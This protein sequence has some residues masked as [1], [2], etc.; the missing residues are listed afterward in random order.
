[1]TRTRVERDIAA[2]P[3][4]TALLL[5]GP[6]AV[7]LWPGVTRLGGDAHH[8]LAEAALPSPR[9]G[10]LRAT[11]VAVRA[12]PPLR[13]PTSYVTRFEFRGDDVPATTGVLTLAASRTGSAGVETHASLVLEATEGR[14]VSGLRVMAGEFLANLAAAAEQRSFAA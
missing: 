1:M 6:T 8:V 14:T 4:S 9:D 2:D 13:T 11:T 12:M 7:E 3:V 5:A 10:S